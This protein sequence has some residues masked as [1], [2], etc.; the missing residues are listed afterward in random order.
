V[1]FSNPLFRAVG[2]AAGAVIVLGVLLIAWRLGTWAIEPKHAWHQTAPPDFYVLDAIGGRS[3]RLELAPDGRFHVQGGQLLLIV[4]HLCVGKVEGA[5]IFRVFTH[6]QL[7]AEYH[8]VRIDVVGTRPLPFCREVRNMVPLLYA[9]PPGPWTYRAEIDVSV[10]PAHH[11][12]ALLEE[13]R[14]WLESENLQTRL[15][16]HAEVDR[17]ELARLKQLEER[18]RQQLR[19]LTEMGRVGAALAARVQLLERPERGRPADEVQ[20]P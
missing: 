3:A 6:E 20:A 19:Q 2:Y 17:Q 15:A 14:F 1:K 11:V 8:M 13:T 5:S 16:R 4:R 7:D 9:F 10:N 12:H 18:N